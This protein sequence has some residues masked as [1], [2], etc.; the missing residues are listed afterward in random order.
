MDEL[1]KEW[2]ENITHWDKISIK[3]AELVIAQTQFVLNHSI[4]TAKSIHEKADKLT[5]LL[6]PSITAVSIYILSG[7]DKI[8]DI[9]HL[10]GVVAFIVLVVSQAIIYFNITAYE[11][12]IPGNHPETLINNNFINADDTEEEQ[13]IQIALHICSENKSRTKVNDKKNGRD[14]HRNQVALKIAAIGLILSPLMG[15]ILHLF[16]L[17]SLLSPCQ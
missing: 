7:L 1:K 17:R 12:R 9:A 15:F 10:S 2:P 16:L 6:L 4:E 3:T 11:I 13:F 5:A 14:S 8:T